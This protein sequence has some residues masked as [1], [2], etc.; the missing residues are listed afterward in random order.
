MKKEMV[1]QTEYTFNRHK[2]FPDYNQMVGYFQA[3]SCIENS[4]GKSVLDLPCGDGLLTK[5]YCDHFPEVVGV[6]ASIKQI[7]TAKKIC[8]GAKFYH[9][10]IED[11]EINEK[12]DNIF[13][14]NILEHVV[15]PIQIIQKAATFLN[16]KG[17]IIIQVPNAEAVNRKIAVLMG[18]LAN[19][20]EFSPYDTKIAGHRREYSMELLQKDILK[21]GL[22]IKKTGGVFYKSL[23]MSQ[24]D[25]LLKKGPWKTGGFGWGRVGQENTK[26]WKFEFCR[27]SYEYGKTKPTECNLIYAVV[28]K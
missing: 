6:D 21:S 2:Y 20:Y 14:L 24:F 1:R 27:A 26:D 17:H 16:P 8:P 7:R 23:S 28:T 25:F 10:L 22:K 18:T 4:I 9:S 19:L 15:S 5:Y 12:F 3:L 11:L 13:M